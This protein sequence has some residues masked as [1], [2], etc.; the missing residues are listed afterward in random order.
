MSEFR[1][2]EWNLDHATRHGVGR[3]EAERIVDH[4]GRGWPRRGG[5]DKLMV[6][7][8]GEGGRMVQVV[9]LLDADGT[10]FIIHAMPLTT[11]RRRGRRR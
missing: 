2:N 1:W 4:P 11:R 8:R 6:Q 10:I 5:R 9:Y 3:L 7:G